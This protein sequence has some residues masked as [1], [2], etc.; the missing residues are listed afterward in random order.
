MPS[1]KRL[2][3]Q[4]S[5]TIIELPTVKYYSGESV[6]E[7]EGSRDAVSVLKFLSK[8]IEN[9]VVNINDAD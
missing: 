9:P 7:Y 2:R 4:T 6:V 1:H 5:K 3:V 8:Y